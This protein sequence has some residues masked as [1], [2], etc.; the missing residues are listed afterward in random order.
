MLEQPTT[1]Q[2][3]GGGTATCHRAPDTDCLGALTRVDEDRADQ[4]EGGRHQR[5]TGNT[6]QHA[7]GNEH[8]GTD[9]ESGDDRGET[10]ADCAD[11]E[12]FSP[13]DPVAERTHGDEQTGEHERI[14]VDDPQQLRAARLEVGADERKRKIEHRAVDCDEQHSKGK[15]YQA[16]PVTLC[17]PNLVGIDCRRLICRH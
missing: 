8:L 16:R 6:L 14:D 5:C 4:T 1:D 9:S 13:T 2:R 17:R 10:E 3:A 15:D 11:Q 7:G 12:Q